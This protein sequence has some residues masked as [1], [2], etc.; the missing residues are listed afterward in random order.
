MWYNFK[1]GKINYKYDIRVSFSVF[2]GGLLLDNLRILDIPETASNLNMSNV[3]LLK[4]I[5]DF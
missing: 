5:N 2:L 1:Y 3:N 4:H